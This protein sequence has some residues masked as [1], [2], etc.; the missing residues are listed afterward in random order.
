LSKQKLLSEQF[1]IQGRHV[2]EAVKDVC[3]NLNSMWSN[4]GL[5]LKRIVQANDAL[6]NAERQYLNYIFTSPYYWQ[7]ILQRR[8]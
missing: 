6:S 8:E 1:G 4:L 7:L 3:M 5:K 2:T